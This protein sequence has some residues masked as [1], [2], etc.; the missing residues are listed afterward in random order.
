MSEIFNFLLLNGNDIEHIY[1]FI[2]NR[3]IDINSNLGP[4]GLNIIS[5]ELWNIIENSNVPFTFINSTIYK[6]DTINRIKE[7]MV[8]YLN[9]KL[10]VQELYLFSLVQETPILSNIYSQLTQN[11]ALPLTRN[12]LNNF[13]KNI[14]NGN[15]ANNTDTNQY[16]NQTKGIYLFE[17]FYNLNLNTENIICK[18]SLGQKIEYL[19]KNYPFVVNPY[20]SRRKR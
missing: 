14:N 17:D 6:D 10:S 19:N 11:D 16:V 1:I 9:I 2:G 8:K 7:K 20:R 5:K 12:R 3:S 15:I 18:I 13:I 4:N